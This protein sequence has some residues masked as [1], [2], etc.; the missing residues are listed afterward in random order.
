MYRLFLIFLLLAPGSDQSGWKLKKYE[1]GIAVYTRFSD[2]SSLK[3]V[4][5]VNTVHASLSSIV[6]LLMD[7]EGCTK[8]IYACGESQTVRNVN[9][10][11][12]YQYFLINVPVPFFNRDVATHIVATQDP[13]TK[14]VTVHSKG[15]PDFVSRKKDVVRVEDYHSTYILKPLGNGNILVEFELYVDPGGNIPPWLVN[16]NMVRGPYKTTENMIEMLNTPE[17]RNAIVKGIRD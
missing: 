10:L 5:A 17:Y 15:V 4:R 11:D 12:Q 7:G 13:K 14:I 8:W 2:A 1:K 16:A 9:E 3:E 6:K